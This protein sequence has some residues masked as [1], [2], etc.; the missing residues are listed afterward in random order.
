M[1]HKACHIKV[2]SKSCI[3]LWILPIPQFVLAFTKSKNLKEI[4]KGCYQFRSK[5]LYFESET[6]KLTIF[7]KL[8]VNEISICSEFCLLLQPTCFVLL[9]D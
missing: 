5:H 8:N 2:I 6:Y 7:T 4:L 3:N 9:K 1:V